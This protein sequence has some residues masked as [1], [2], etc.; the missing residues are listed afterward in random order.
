[1]DDDFEEQI[2]LMEELRADKELPE[3]AKTVSENREKVQNAKPLYRVAAGQGAYNPERAVDAIDDAEEGFVYA[4]VVGDSMLPILQDKDI[5][6]IQPMSE[7]TPHD[8]TLVKV[9]GE[10]ATIKYVEIVEN[11]LWLR[12][13]NKEVFEDKFYSV[14]EIIN[15]PITIQG[16]VVEFR[17]K[18]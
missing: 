6:K 1:M 14:Q 3:I 2:A 18:I 7:T 5:V 8:L 10:H 15:L 12:A 11:G 9:D 17:R 16:K 13:E 4:T